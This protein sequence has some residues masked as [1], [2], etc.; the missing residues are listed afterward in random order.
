M[1]SLVEHLN[2][3]V[4]WWSNTITAGFLARILTYWNNS[5]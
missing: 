3:N 4:L 5:V 2:F 1:K